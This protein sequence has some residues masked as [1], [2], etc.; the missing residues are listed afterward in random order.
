MRRRSHSLAR[1]AGAVA[2]VAAV[3]V[4]GH[5]LAS[6]DP[7]AQAPG[8]STGS[9]GGTGSFGGPMSVD[10]PRLKSVDNFRDVA[11]IGPGYATADGKRVA[12]GVFYR[13][14]VLDPSDADLATLQALRLTAAY[15][16]RGPAEIAKQPDRLP[17]G[18]AYRNIPIL[19]GNIE[20]QAARV[21]SP[22]EARELARTVYRSFVTGAGERAAIAQM[23]TELANTEGAQVFHCNAGKDRTGWVAATLLGLAGVPRATIMSDFLLTNEYSAVSIKARRD[24]IVAQYGEE[25]A[26]IFDPIFGVE[27]GF[28]E[29]ALAQMDQSYGSFEGYLTTGL[30]LDA[31]IVSA[32]RAKLVN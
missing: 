2:A 27:A 8:V 29:S 26:K 15:D 9:S 13:S 32:L 21:R 30:G 4:A 28:L 23:L 17:G 31:G 20:D 3:F 12:R 11:G 22:E 25:A 7:A 18:V 5:G 24:S 19:G 10:T 14:N 6:A 16:L 1:S